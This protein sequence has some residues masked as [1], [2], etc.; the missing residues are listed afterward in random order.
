MASVSPKPTTFTDRIK[1]RNPQPSEPAQTVRIVDA[2]NDFPFA[3]ID[4]LRVGAAHAACEPSPDAENIDLMLRIST[5]TLRRYEPDLLPA[6]VSVEYKSDTSSGAPC[7]DPTTHTL[8]TDAISTES[9]HFEPSF[10]DRRWLKELYLCVLVK[11]Q[12]PSGTRGYA[13]FGVF[14]DTLL[15]F[16]DRYQT[17]QP[18][19]PNQLKAIVLARSTGEPCVEI[20]EFMRMKFNFHQEIA[21]LELSRC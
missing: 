7:N 4:Y 14:S 20:R 2:E 18:F 15:D 8:A 13:Y 19:N 11:G 9:N 10:L 17:N 1:P 16:F 6:K 12:L 3:H 5:H 21:I